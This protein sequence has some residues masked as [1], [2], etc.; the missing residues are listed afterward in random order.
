[1][2]PLLNVLHQVWGYPDFRPLQ[3][4]IAESV[5]SGK[6]TVALLPTG[7]GKSL[8]FQ[9]PGLVLPG[10][11]VVVS[12]LVSLMND[13]VERL[14][15][16]GIG[17]ATLPA[18]TTE[19]G[20]Q[21]ALVQAKQG[22]LRFLYVSP[23][24][25]Q[26]GNFIDKIAQAGVSLIAVDEAHCVSQWGHDFRPSFLKIKELMAALP[27]VPVMALTASATPE[28]LKD[29]CLQLGISE[30]AIF[31][32]SFYRPNLILEVHSSDR[33]DADAALL[34]AKS[35]GANI[36]Y[37]RSRKQAEEGAASLTR[38]GVPSV[39]Y[40]AGYAAADR[41][42]RQQGWM[43]ES[44]PTMVATT[45]FGMGI[46]KSNVRTVVHWDMP[47]SLEAYYQE[48]G[49]GGRDGEKAVAASFFTANSVQSLRRRAQSQEILWEEA[50]AFYS[51]VASQGQ[52]AVGQGLV[53]HAFEPERAAK[54]LGWPLAKVLAAGA[55]F[56]R[57][58]SLTF[59]DGWDRT[60][61]VRMLK[62]GADLLEALDNLPWAENL[63]SHLA[64]HFPGIGQV[65]QA[66]SL[67][68]LGR[69]T[70]MQPQQ[71]GELLTKL[72]GYGLVDY[73][74]APAKSQVVW[75]HYR[76][77]EGHLP[78]PRV[79]L[80]AWLD[81]QREKRAAV[82]AYFAS[83][84]CRFQNLLHYFGETETSP[85]GKCDR[86]KTRSER[87]SRALL[88][89]RL[90]MGG[91]LLSDLVDEWAGVDADHLQSLLQQGVDEGWWKR[92]KT[93]HYTL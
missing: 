33:P 61:K 92:S 74:P 39:A 28:V 66:V 44:P 18:G 70:G 90:G 36:V 55:F 57:M 47:E 59:S 13:Q 25:L 71:V 80:E 58:G 7:G 45:A 65:E 83:E 62:M 22:I 68:D 2:D 32:Q 23:E 16:L 26:A 21:T 48:V 6:S 52:V 8:C 35:E 11:T 5:L 85:C 78:F 73:R 38:L 69:S 88:K 76:E 41:A 87:T 64:R 79:R 63:L 3:R 19:S 40:H 82:E 24:R 91:V 60:T 84:G 43:A 56:E 29:I 81:R 53:R 42:K 1:M 9:V 86:C 46:D 77:S 30:A 51:V 67:P 10:L 20:I 49:R 15:S 17:A 50:G 72:Q 93:G 37:V 54:V 31:R 34:L 4:D 75:N 89:R 14:Q 12:P 27:H